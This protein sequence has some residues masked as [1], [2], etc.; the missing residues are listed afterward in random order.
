MFYPLC[1][2]CTVEY[3]SVCRS[4]SVYRFYTRREL[5]M[6]HRTALFEVH[7]AAGQ[8]AQRWYREEWMILEGSLIVFG[9]VRRIVY[10]LLGRGCNN[11]MRRCVWTLRF[12]DHVGTNRTMVKESAMT[13]FLWRCSFKGVVRGKK[14][15]TPYGISSSFSMITGDNRDN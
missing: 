14:L 15:L 4:T 1:E 12:Y 9:P 10:I 2:F 13:A 8:K 5:M 3:E 7:H 6:K 11:N